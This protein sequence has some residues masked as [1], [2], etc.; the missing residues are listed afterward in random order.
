[1]KET[2]ILKELAQLTSSN[3]QELLSIFGQF[4]A[5]KSDHLYNHSYYIDESAEFTRYVCAYQEKYSF[6]H[7][8]NSFIYRCKSLHPQF[9]FRFKII[10]DGLF[11]SYISYKIGDLPKDV[12][13]GQF[14]F[15]SKD[16]KLDKINNKSISVRIIV[17]TNCHNFKIERLKN[18]TLDDGLT[19]SQNI[20]STTISI[21]TYINKL[22]NY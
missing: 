20:I 8:L 1:M 3:Q 16:V 6:C 14:I 19:V 17:S 22:L 13:N 2:N 11:C 18:F 21:L 5:L 15:N 12:E 4:L 10:Y 9:P 7:E